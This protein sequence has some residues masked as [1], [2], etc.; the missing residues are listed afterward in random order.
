VITD[1]RLPGLSGHQL[2]LKLMQQ[3]PS[4]P[5]ILIT[6]HGDISLAVQAMQDGAYD[7]I[8]KPFA[9]VRLTESVKRAIEKRLLT[10]ENKTLK[11]SPA[12]QRNTRTTDHWHH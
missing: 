7:F 8:E 6:G 1:I 4:L 3:D 12:S 2:L 10:E 9:S 5:V 11:K